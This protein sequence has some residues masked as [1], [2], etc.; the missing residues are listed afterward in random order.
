MS[1][2]IMSTSSRRIKLVLLSGFTFLFG[3]WLVTGSLSTTFG[4]GLDLTQAVAA[5]GGGVIQDDRYVGSETCSACHEAQF[6][7]VSDTKHG[8][9]HTLDSWKGK[10]VGCESCHGPGKE[11]AESGD[12]T[13]IISFKNKNSKEISETCLSC[14]A[15]KESHNNFRR[16]DHWR[17]DVGCTDCHTA[18]SMHHSNRA[19]FSA[20]EKPPAKLRAK[21]HQR[22]SSGAS[23]SFA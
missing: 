6:K 20:P 23:R 18:R 22:C 21:Q 19:R 13:K 17:N 5:G 10:V 8:K 3:L 7:S 1:E 11:H 9:L 12:I 4:S 15:G 16:G 2:A 14:H